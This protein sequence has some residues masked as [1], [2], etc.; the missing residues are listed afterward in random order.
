MVIYDG[1]MSIESGCPVGLGT[2][3]R[4]VYSVCFGGVLVSETPAA[5]VAAV[6]GGVVVVVAGA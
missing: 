4:I 2:E 3:T 1:V 5:V 6:G